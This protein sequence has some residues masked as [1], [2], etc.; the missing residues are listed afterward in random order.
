[1]RKRDQFLANEVV[2]CALCAEASLDCFRRP[3]LLDPD[4]LESHLRQ[5]SAREAGIATRSV[6]ERC[7]EH[8]HR[9]AYESARVR[10]IDSA[11][12]ATEAERQA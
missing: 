12:T 4:F 9:V 5:Y 1:M 11:R 2:E 6:P 7:V 8:F 10:G 3:T